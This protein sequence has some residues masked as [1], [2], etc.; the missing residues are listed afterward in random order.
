MYPK[1]HVLAGTWKA[2]T[3]EKDT[4]LMRRGLLQQLLQFKDNFENALLDDD[5]DLVKQ[6]PDQDVKVTLNFDDFVE[7][8]VERNR[9]EQPETKSQT[10]CVRLVKET[11]P[12]FMSLPLEHQGY[13]P[14]TIVSR[15]GLLLPGNPNIG[16][17]RFKGRH[18]SFVSDQGMRD[19]CDNPE[20]YIDGVV[21]TARRN[22]ALIHLLCLQ[23]FIPNSDITDLFAIE[24]LFDAKRFAAGGTRSADAMTQTADYIN[25][26]PADPNYEWNEWAMRR[27][28]IQMANL[29]NKRTRSTQSNLSHF[30]RNNDTQTYSK[31][32]N[33]DGTM[34]GQ[35]TQTGIDKGTNVSRTSKYITGLRG[36]P[37]TKVTTN[38]LV[39]PET[40]RKA[41]PTP[42][43]PQTTVIMT[44]QI[45]DPHT[46]SRAPIF[47][48]SRM[49]P[50]I[51]S[52][53]TARVIRVG[54][55]CKCRIIKAGNFSVTGTT[56]RSRVGVVT[57]LQA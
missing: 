50:I 52:T 57:N 33:E 47:H 45:H 32:M 27:K 9:D 24:D 17:I 53:Q 48:R 13:C 38:K 12:D 49:G 11:T 42:H 8:I 51:P 5:I 36:K 2:L 19:F 39:L 37:S 25:T 54:Y 1:F 31:Q 4:N 16:V 15:R 40:V 34:P 6:T 35:G 56:T 41:P 10:T 55:C 43:T 44:V 18:Y 14:W 20:K 26:T 21:D 3:R 28:A 30:R 22:P 46:H 7:T 29:C 23:P